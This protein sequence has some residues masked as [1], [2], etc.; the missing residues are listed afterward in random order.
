MQFAELLDSNEVQEIH[1]ASLEILEQVGIRVQNE[2]ARSIYAKHN[3]QVDSSSNVV[4]FPTQVV[5]E[6]RQAF[7]PTFTF[8]GRNPDFDRTIPGDRPVIVTAS[9]APN[10]LD[11]VSGPERRATS[12]DMANIAFLINELPGYDVFSISTLAD[13]APEGQF[14][15]S[16]F[17]PALKNCTKPVRGNT[18]NMKDL[19]DVLELGA[20]VAGGKEAYAERPLITHH[21]CP[22]ISPLTMDIESTESLIYLVEN[23]LPAYGTIVPNAGLTAPMSLIGSLALGN[24]EFLAMSVL[25]QM[26]RPGAPLIYAT[27]STIADL[28]SGSYTPGAVETGLMHMA[29]CQM[30]RFYGVPSG[31]YIGLTNAHSNDAQ[32]GYETGIGTTGAVL[33]GSDMLNLGGL[34]D[35]L[36]AFDFAKA[37]IDNE[38]GL[39]L[40]RFVGFPHVNQDRLALDVIK[41]VGPGGSYMET[42]HTMA[43]MRDTALLTRIANREMRTTWEGGGRP[44]VHSRALEQVNAILGS[45]NLNK[46]PHEIDTLARERF[47]GL[48]TGEGHWP[49]KSE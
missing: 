11:P 2:K 27:L 19:L 16:R 42:P 46:L 32:S 41:Q 15:L 31:G 8:R 13:D 3:C 34:L 17:Y 21:C 40:K 23:K 22:V 9:S 39:M 45:E 35:S 28:R 36:M 48:V 10:I 4:K 43:H 20:I 25:M 1:T 18:P 24:A 30:A 12:H 49:L 5:E 14:S 38:I 26:I 6:H 29:H 44:D 7:T 33:A 47:A 37:V